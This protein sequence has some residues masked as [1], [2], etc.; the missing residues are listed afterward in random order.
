M[1]N[2]IFEQAE[3]LVNEIKYVEQELLDWKTVKVDG[4]Y[5]A[6]PEG[7]IKMWSP[8]G[9]ASQYTIN[10]IHAVAIKKLHVDHYTT[11]LE[12]LKVEFDNL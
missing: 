11:Y 1:K 7:Q 4:E 8:S 2:E 6:M 3:K 5:S 12:K 10:P 9:V